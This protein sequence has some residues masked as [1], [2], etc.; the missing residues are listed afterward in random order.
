MNKN[1]STAGGV[2][3]TLL[4]LTLLAVHPVR[5][6]AQATVVNNGKT[7]LVTDATSLATALGAQDNWPAEWVSVQ[8]IALGA[9][10]TLGTTYTPAEALSVTFDGQ[11]HTVTLDGVALTK[12]VAKTGAIHNLRVAFAP[13]NDKNYAVKGNAYVASE[14]AGEIRGVV[15]V[16]IPQPLAPEIVNGEPLYIGGLVGVNKGR[17]RNCR[18]EMIVQVNIAQ[19][20]TGDHPTDIYFGL[21][22]GNNDE[23]GHIADCFVSNLVG[24]AYTDKA[25]DRAAAAVNAKPALEGAGSFTSDAYNN[26]SGTFDAELLRCQAGLTIGES[27]GEIARVLS[28]NGARAVSENT[29]VLVSGNA[30]KFSTSGADQ[31]FLTLIELG[32]CET[33]DDALFTFSDPLVWTLDAETIKGDK[34]FRK[35]TPTM[36]DGSNGVDFA[37]DANQKPTLKADNA[38]GL[39]NIFAALAGPQAKLY[40]QADVTIAEDIDLEETQVDWDALNDASV[41]AKLPELPTIPYYNGHFRGAVLRHLA[42]RSQGLFDRLGPQAVVENLVLDKAAI[43]VDPQLCAAQGDNV[44][45]PI[46]AREVDAGA[47]LIVGFAGN[48]YVDAAKF[49]ADRQTLNLA[50]V[51]QY[52]EE[53]SAINGYLFL[54]RVE[55]TST[56]KICITI[57]QNLGTGRNKPNGGYN[58]PKQKVAT[59][60]QPAAANKGLSVDAYATADDAD[61]MQRVFPDEAFRDGSVAYWLNFDGKG[62]SGKY[63]PRW[64]QGASQPVPA[65]LSLDNG[66]NAVAKVQYNVNDEAKVT[67]APV[68]CNNGGSLRVEYSERPTTV[69]NG[70]ALVRLE[71]GY[72]TMAYNSN[73]PVSI[74]FAATSTQEEAT[75]TTPKP[76][77]TTEAEST[78]PTAQTTT[79]T[80]PAETTTRPVAPNPKPSTPSG[81]AQQGTLD[82]SAPAAKTF[83]VAVSHHTVTVTGAAGDKQ[84]IDLVGRVVASTTGT[85]LTAPAKGIYFLVVGGEITKIGIRD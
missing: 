84:L 15:A 76:D 20:S 62:Y 3:A 72:A 31:D 64:S 56:N 4:A 46:F 1:R 47:Q 57:K 51:D 80:P 7:L 6:D 68:Y 23:Q 74:T 61:E 78:T 29:I 82:V 44:F 71:E 49:D 54:D 69:T 60:G 67:A 41:K 34:Q 79:T 50:L 21:L 70:T 42:A 35:P 14:N 9:D 33:T 18:V 22:A 81:A 2:L 13:Q 38:E 75:E 17:I 73:A 37:L 83:S 26:A 36:A 32:S 12:S 5:A 52:N 65:L 25:E 39:R 58:P 40:E 43:Y 16:G 53:S 66:N 55:T 19:A 27:K 77:T 8:V 28:W 48:A 30:R 45:V 63:V 10:V 24:V 11:G 85:T 59:N